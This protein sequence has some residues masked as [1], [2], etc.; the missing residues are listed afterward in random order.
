MGFSE[1]KYWSGVPL[2]S[3]QFI[4][5][6][7]NSHYRTWDL[8]Y[9]WFP[10][11]G[12]GETSWCYY[13][14]LE[15]WG[16]IFCPHRQSSFYRCHTPTDSLKPR[17]FSHMSTWANK[18]MGFLKKW[19]RDALL[20]WYPYLSQHDLDQLIITNITPPLYDIITVH[21][22]FGG[23]SYNLKYFLPLFSEV[24]QY[25]AII[26]TRTKHISQI[27]PFTIS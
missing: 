18:E 23:Q 11:W 16:R 26:T 21:L 4:S 1:Q 22:R 20:T 27:R 2:P 25:W 24:H 14:S 13:H 3:P 9:I 19:I 7:S 10:L 17:S 12:R 15:K 8:I 6:L 5:L